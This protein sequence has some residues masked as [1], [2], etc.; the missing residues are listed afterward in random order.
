MRSR[1]VAAEPAH[2]GARRQHQAAGGHFTLSSP[3]DRG[4]PGPADTPPG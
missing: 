4:D 3:V 1:A 2:A